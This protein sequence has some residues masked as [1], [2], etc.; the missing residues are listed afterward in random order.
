MNAEPAIDLTGMQ[1][2]GG[3]ETSTD[4]VHED[5]VLP[6]GHL[7][8][9]RRSRYLHTYSRKQLAKRAEAMRWRQVALAR[10]SSSAF[11]EYAFVEEKTGIPFKQ[12]WFH[13]EWHAAWDSHQRVLIIAPRDHAKTSNVVGRAIWELGRDQNLRSKIVCASDGRAKERLFEIDQHI[14][15]ND[16]VREV[17]PDLE[18]DPKAPWNAHRLVLRRRAKHRDASVEALGIN[19]TATGGRADLLIADD[20]VDR[21]NALSFP[22]LRE[23]IKQAWKSDWTNLLEPDSRVW[24]I[25]TLWSPQDLSHELMDNPAYTVMRYDIDEGFGSI[26]KDKWPELA[27]RQRY[28]EIGSIEFNRAFR[29]QAIDQ[30]SALIQPTWFQFAD[31]RQH[32]GFNQALER[33]ELIFLTS[34][35]PAGTPTGKKDQD[36]TG[37]CA[38]AIHR[39]TGMVYIVDAWHQRISVAK[40][41]ETVYDEACRYEPWQVLIEKV[42]QS[43]LDEWVINEHP[44]LAGLVRVTKPRVSKAMRLMGATPL[45]E[46]GKVL[47]SHHLDPNSPAFPGNRGSIVDEL[48]EFPF[49]KHDDMV[50]AFSQLISV[51]RTHFLDVDSDGGENVVDLV[52]DDNDGYYF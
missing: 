1:Q 29:N 41:A 15:T 21:R 8:R 50:D 35:D 28:A 44:E 48:Q 33:D 9:L 30:D 26:W 31:L 24:Y 36:Y 40:S 39:D 7:P 2:S 46:K 37:Q 17:F 34:Y 18:P 27:L 45:L 43:T 51:A 22:A 4:R 13:D 19:S 20:V 5:Y 6:V 16:R 3:I 12:Q 32:D 14:T 23:Q 38:A 49:G 47:F 10:K 25:C 42:G 11:M 52:T